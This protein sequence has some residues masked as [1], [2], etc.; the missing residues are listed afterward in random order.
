MEFDKIIVLLFLKLQREKSGNP[1]FSAPL[2]S[3]LNRAVLRFNPMNEEDETGSTEELVPIS[4]SSV[5]TSKFY[6]HMLANYM[7]FCLFIFPP[8]F[9]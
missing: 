8:K 5:H 1:S 3:Y 4:T 7:K 2:E 6:L 9:S